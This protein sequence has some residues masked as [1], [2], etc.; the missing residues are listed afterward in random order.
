M[1]RYGILTSIECE[2][3]WYFDQCD[4]IHCNRF[5]YGLWDH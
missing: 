3:L 5:H 4:D 1:E 2:T